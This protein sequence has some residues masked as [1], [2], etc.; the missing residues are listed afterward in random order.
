MTAPI[1][2]PFDGGPTFL[3]TMISRSHPSCETTV[4]LTTMPPIGI[5]KTMTESLAICPN[6]PRNHPSTFDASS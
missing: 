1:A 3:E 5:A 2:S 4:S 6:S